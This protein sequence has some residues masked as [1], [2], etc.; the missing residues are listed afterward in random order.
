MSDGEL[1][2]DFDPAVWIDTDV[3]GDLDEWALTT[4]QR[5]Y[6]E[7]GLRPDARAVTA[8][9]A[10]LLSLAESAREVP[11]LCLIHLTQPELG[12]R[13]LVTMTAEDAGDGSK[14][15]LLTLV[16]A[17]DPD[18]VEPAVVSEVATQLGMALRARRYVRSTDDRDPPG[19]VLGAIT[20]AWHV[21]MV[22]A[23]LRLSTASFDLADLAV[24]ESDVDDLAQVVS[25]QAS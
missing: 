3:E 10:A 24:I 16:G 7:A 8:L 23:D 21:P 4:A 20:Y 19:T 12:P 9:S 13:A 11:G 17:D 6:A 25:I 22:D 18:L 2:I 5:C 15:S 14:A 1:V